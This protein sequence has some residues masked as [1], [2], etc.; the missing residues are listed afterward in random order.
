[1]RIGRL[2]LLAYSR[3]VTSIIGCTIEVL[4]IDGVILKLNERIYSSSCKEVLRDFRKKNLFK[5]K[6]Y[7]AVLYNIASIYPE[8]NKL[9]LS[10]RAL[11]GSE[12]CT[13]FEWR[14]SFKCIAVKVLKRSRELLH[15]WLIILNVI[16]EWST[17]SLPTQI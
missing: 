11:K 10:G 7:G 12:R 8:N 4:R 1:M 16:S 15:R 14:Y 5:P 3:C 13:C 9:S 6:L 17:R 2:I